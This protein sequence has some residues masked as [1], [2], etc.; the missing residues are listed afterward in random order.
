MEVVIVSDEVEEESLL[1]VEVAPDALVAV[2]VADTSLDAPAGA[3]GV[4]GVLDAPDVLENTRD[5]EEDSR[6]GETKVDGDD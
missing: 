6:V 3:S 1:V 4:A 2:T 5:E